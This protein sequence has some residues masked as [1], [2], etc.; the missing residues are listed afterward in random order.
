[1]VNASRLSALDGERN[2]GMENLLV[3]T[4]SGLAA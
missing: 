4:N 3:G 2:P 1:M